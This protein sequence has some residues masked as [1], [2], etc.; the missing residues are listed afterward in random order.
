LK[1]FR[2]VLVCDFSE[3]T[4]MVFDAVDELENGVTE[5]VTRLT[6][7]VDAAFTNPPAEQK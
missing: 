6:K 4:T 7:E 5:A 2:I 3:S 1:K